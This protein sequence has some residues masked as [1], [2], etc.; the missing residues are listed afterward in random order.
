[1]TRP[2]ILYSFVDF[3]RSSRVRWLAAELGLEVQERRL[4][5]VGGEHRGEAHRQRHPFG[6]VPAAEIEGDAIWESGAI[7]QHLVETHPEAGLAP[8][9]GSAGRGAYLS[10][11]FFT[12]STFDNA[13]FEVFHNTL[14][15]PDEA[16][17]AKGVAR[18]LPLLEALEARLAGQDYV[19]GAKFQ[20]PDLMLGHALALLAMAKALDRSAHP[21]LGRYLARLAARPAAPRATL[22]AA[23]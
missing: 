18:I 11:L 2:I 17:R 13:A 5:F 1:M 20:L 14:I 6:L 9:P 21:T 8:P 15:R 16:A 10:W 19:L 4:N 12:T 7:C 22:F 3:D 23:V